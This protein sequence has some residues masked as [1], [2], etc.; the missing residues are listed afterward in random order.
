MPFLVASVVWD[1]ALKSY[2]GDLSAA[3]LPFLAE[4]A[5]YG[6]ETVF[7]S[8]ESLDRLVAHG[9]SLA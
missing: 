7:E 3:I 1:V 8:P 5:N 4:P 2:V 9:G 6:F